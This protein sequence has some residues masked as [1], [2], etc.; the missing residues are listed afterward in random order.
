MPPW[1]IEATRLAI[2]RV[3]GQ[4][5]LDLARPCLRSLSDR[6]FYAAFHYQRATATLRR[7][8][9][10]HLDPDDPMP[11]IFGQDEVGWNR[12]NVVIRKLGA[13]ITACIQSVHA[14][15]DILASAVFYALALDRTVK[16]AHGKFVNHA[17]VTNA[18]ASMP[19]LQEVYAALRSAVKGSN[20]EHLAALANQAKHYSIVFPALNTD[21]TG[22]RAEQHMLVLPSFRARSKSYPQ[23][24]VSEF[25]P[26][27]HGHVSQS[28]LATGLALHAHLQSTA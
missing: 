28:I 7:Y 8:V 14:L 6:Q 11:T 16:P 21:L 25:L 17:F 27:V 18:I 5:Q 1:D 13:D 20:Y 23:V 19:G 9:R 12:F 2:A 15:P 24:L 4:S 26:P 22:E 10:E 3:H